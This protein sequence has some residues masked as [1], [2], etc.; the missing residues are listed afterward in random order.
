MKCQEIRDSFLGFF[1]ERGHLIMP[2][3]PLVTDDPTTLFTVAGM[4]PYIAA[5]RGEEKPPPHGWPAFKCARMGDLERVGAPPPSRI[6]SRCSATSHSA[7]TSSR[8]P[9]V[10]LEVRRGCAGH[11]ARDLWITVFQDDDEAERL[12]HEHIGVPLQ[13]IV[14]LG[15]EEL[16]AA[17]ALG[18]AV[19]PLPTSTSTSGRVLAAADPTA[20]PPASATVSSSCGTWSSRCTPRPRTGHSPSY[21]R[22]GWTP[23]WALSA[24][25]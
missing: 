25:R 9:S 16:V 10:R 21:L 24:W 2:G 23:A 22:R 19:R 12:W 15:R 1:A 3:A 7:I 4:Q 11:P 17:G 5:F 14:R 13:R 18:G 8:A 20:A 6:S